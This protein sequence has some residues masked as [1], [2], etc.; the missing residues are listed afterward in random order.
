MPW[1]P[2]EKKLGGIRFIVLFLNSNSDKQ[3][4]STVILAAVVSTKNVIL[5][6]VVSTKKTKHHTVWTPVNA[7]K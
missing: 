4:L 7:Q 5:V 6:A 1:D 2:E 3:I